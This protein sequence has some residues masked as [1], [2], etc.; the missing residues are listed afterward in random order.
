LKRRDGRLSVEFRTGQNIIQDPAQKLYIRF[1]QSECHARLS[2]R[3]WIQGLAREIRF[4]S[5]KFDRVNGKQ[6]Y[7][8]DQHGVDVS[9]QAIENEKHVA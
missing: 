2:G 7:M 9:A 6:N 1:A 4:D 8:K 3:G 5:T